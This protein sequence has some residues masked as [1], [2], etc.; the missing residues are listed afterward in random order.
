[1]GIEAHKD[2]IN[3]KGPELQGKSDTVDG[4]SATHFGSANAIVLAS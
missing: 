2:L 4:T 3:Q 1:M